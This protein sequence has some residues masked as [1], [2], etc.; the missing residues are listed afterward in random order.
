MHLA[1]HPCGAPALHLPTSVNSATAATPA[2][3]SRTFAL[4]SCTCCLP[5][6]HC[7]SSMLS[8]SDAS[9][10]VGTSWAQGLGLL[11]YTVKVHFS[12]HAVSAGGGGDLSA[13]RWPVLLA[14]LL[15]AGCLSFWLN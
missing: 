8:L 5:L 6:M 7:M 10:S 2:T 15:R 12:L 3:V 9:I 1:W 4:S 11:P 14:K 13:G